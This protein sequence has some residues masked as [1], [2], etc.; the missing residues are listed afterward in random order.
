[1]SWIDLTHTLFSGMPVY[2]GDEPPR[3]NDVATLVDHGYRER[4]IQMGSHAGTHMDAPAHMLEAGLTLDLMP[5]DA[6]IGMGFVL[7]ARGLKSIERC[8]L[9][10]FECAISNCDF[11]LLHTGWSERWGRPDYFDA[12]PCL[13]PDAALY[14]GGKNLKGVGVDAPSVD[15]MDSADYPIHK[16]LLERGFVIIEN[17][18]NLDQLLGKSFEF[19][20]LPLNLE[21]AE[22]SPVRAM[23]RVNHETHSCRSF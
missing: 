23:A 1:M 16:S 5:L 14:L 15:A 22:G 9:E 19:Y 20:A 10:A 21:N 6:F 3:F 2:P 13:T 12:I 4:R 18:M 17:L 11:L 8:H 7:D